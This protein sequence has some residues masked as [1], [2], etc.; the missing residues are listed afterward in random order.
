MSTPNPVPTLPQAQAALVLVQLCETQ[1]GTLNT[2]ASAAQ[3]QV[4]T[5]QNWNPATDL[6]NAQAQLAGLQEGITLMMAAMEAQQALIA[7]YNAANP[8]A[9]LVTS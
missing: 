3:A 5:L 7:Q 2:Q 6:A 4:T 1:L 8:G 9:P